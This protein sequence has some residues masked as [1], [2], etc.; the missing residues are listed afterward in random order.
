M[1]LDINWR[2]Y[3]FVKSSAS[4]FDR[5]KYIRT[6][7]GSFKYIAGGQFSTFFIIGRA[8]TTSQ[9]N[10]LDE[11]AARFNDILQLD[12]PDGYK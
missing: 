2:M 11:E 10:L 5:R 1:N 9:Q 12:E 3:V 7:W 8:A 6:T 4:N